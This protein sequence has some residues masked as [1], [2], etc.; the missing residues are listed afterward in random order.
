MPSGT[1]DPKHWHGFNDGTIDMN[2]GDPN[3]A[4]WFDYGTILNAGS[5]SVF[6]SQ[7]GTYPAPGHHMLTVAPSVVAQSPI[8]QSPVVQSPMLLSPVSQSDVVQSSTFTMTGSSG[9]DGTVIAV[10]DLGDYVVGTAG[11]GTGNFTGGGTEVVSP[12]QGATSAGLVIVP[13]FDSSVTSSSEASE[14]ENAV[15]V[16]IDYYESL[17]ST[18]VT[19]TIEFGLG[20][21][22]G[23]T[24]ESNAL[25]ESES[26]G[27][28]TNY[29]TDTVTSKVKN[30]VTTTSTVVSLSPALAALNTHDEA[31]GASSLPTSNPLTSAPDYFLTFAQEQALD[32]I[33]NDPLDGYV[34][35]SDT[36]PFTFDPSNR[37]VSGEYDAIGVLEHEITEV[38]GRVALYTTSYVSA[39]DLFRYSSSETLS[40]TDNAAYFSINDGK[41]ALAWYNDG[42]NGGDPGD[43]ASSGSTNVVA[44][45]Y[46]AFSSPGSAQTVSAT[47]L[48]VLD[49]VGYTVAT[50][51]VAGT[52]ILTARGEV[53]VEALSVGDLVP[54]RFAG[55]APIRWIGHRTIDCRRHPRRRLVAPVCVRAGAFG[56][57]Q[58]NRDLY[59]SPDHAVA[60]DDVLVPIRLLINGAS[61]V[62]DMTVPLIKYF[63]IEL[64]RHDLV[65]AEGLA[66]ESYLDTGNRGVFAN[67]GSALILHPDM[68]ASEGQLRRE[69]ESCLPLMTSAEGVE[70]LW[71]DLAD[72]AVRMGLSLPRIETTHD[73]A[74]TVV[75]DGQVLEPAWYAPSG[76]G[77]G[78]S[79]LGD[80]GTARGRYG[81]SIPGPVRHLRLRSR[82][83]VPSDLLP[84]TEDQRCL[85]VMVQRLEIRSCM[86]TERI[87]MD[88]SRLRDG[89]WAVERD[90]SQSWRWTTGDAALPAVDKAAVLTVT[91]GET[92]AYAVDGSTASSTFA[93]DVFT[94]LFRNITLMAG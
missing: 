85:G 34:G 66:A 16:A 38:M 94:D 46:D 43:W 93:G 18:P 82:C 21:I 55:M 31:F 78:S 47:D 48:N 17:I 49:M 70:P 71:R 53:A 12:V 32:L 45:S 77:P 92:L 13:V 57:N 7:G 8:A 25:G 80:D 87:T 84:W 37:S 72:W 63:H 83:A 33:T 65:M 52:R 59:V 41:T 54:T 86:A 89:W 40:Q 90:A 61:I 76:G 88:D 73:P 58:P 60:M 10:G 6:G 22:D 64:D 75:A 50:C 1:E 79:A 44:D 36:E 23:Q 20:E 69:A 5:A 14:Y 26:L 35:L 51:Y 2:S 30:R 81:F 27:S 29:N 42:S 3:V 62:Q 68:T 74:L 56:P 4:S 91:V 28:L 19:L 15:T 39:M 67:G 9:L 11:V 24:M